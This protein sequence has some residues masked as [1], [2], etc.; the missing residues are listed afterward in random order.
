[1]L[2]QE[3]LLLAMD[4]LKMIVRHHGVCAHSP[5]DKDD[6]AIKRQKYWQKI[7]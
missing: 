4:T 1:M 2:V 7:I 5:A 3:W 6:V